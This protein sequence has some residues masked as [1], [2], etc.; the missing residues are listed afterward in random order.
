MIH[1]AYK[2]RLYPTK[3]QEEFLCRSF[4]ASRW[5]YN[6]FLNYRDSKFKN[7]GVKENYF[8]MAKVLTSLRKQEETSWLKEINSQSLQCTLANLDSAYIKFFKGQTKFPKFKSKNGK[9]SFEIPQNWKIIGNTI[10]IPKLKTPLKFIKHRPIDG[11]ICSIAI[12]KTKTDKYFISFCCEVENNYQQT[13]S[14]EIGIDLGIKDLI[15]CSDG[16]KYENHKFY[17]K[18]LKKLKTLQHHLSRKR[19]DSKRRQKVKLKLAKLHEKITNSREDLYHKISNDLTNKYSL[20]CLESLNVKNMMKNHNLAQ[21]IGDCS[22]F[23]LV[24]K[25][26]YKAKWKGVNVIKIDQFYPSSKTC[27]VCN[28]KKTDL[29]LKEREWVCPK[30]GTHH[31]RDLNAAKNI[32][33]WGKQLIALSDGTSDY[34]CGDEVKLKQVDSTQNVSSAKRLKEGN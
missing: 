18:N 22:W 21:S 3:E 23:S 24:S 29:T 11:K 6:Y 10:K 34:R 27:S 19:K 33:A 14:G 7:E 30:C 16:I 4:G 17:K 28:W 26:E 2:F 1:K 15:I 31:D 32:L 5:V 12:S 8:S 9:Q 13:K 25:I 20:I